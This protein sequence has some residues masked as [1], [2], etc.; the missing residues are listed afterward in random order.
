MSDYLVWSPVVLRVKHYSHTFLIS[1][2]IW[3]SGKS[4]FLE[5]VYV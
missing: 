2:E 4:I 3:Y 1:V 5:Y